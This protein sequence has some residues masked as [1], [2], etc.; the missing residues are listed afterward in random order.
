MI[1]GVHSSKF[2]N[3]K[4]KSN[5]YDAIKRHCIKHP[6]ACDADLTI[7]N[8]LEVICWPT[9][10]VLNPNGLI[11]AE[12]QGEDQ[13]NLV[14]KFVKCCF[15]YYHSS[16]IDSDLHFNSL[17]IVDNFDKLDD[18]YNMKYPTKMCFGDESIL[19]TS[20]TG[21]NRVLAI[22]MVTKK[23]SFIIGGGDCGF[24]DS[25]FKTSK[26]DSPQ[27]LSYDSKAKILYIADTFNDVVRAAHLATQQV[28]TVCGVCNKGLKSIGSYDFIGG[29]EPLA[30]S[31]SSPWD[32]CLIEKDNMNVLII[33]C[34]GTHQIWLYTIGNEENNMLN[35]WKGLK[36]KGQVLIC[37]A[38]NGKERNKNNSYPLQASFAQPSGLSYD[39]IGQ[40]LYL[41]DAESSTIRVISMNDG[42]VKNVVGGDNLQPDNL[43]AYGDCDGKGADAKLQHP[44]DVKFTKIDDKDL[45]IVADTYNGCLKLIDLKTRYCQKILLDAQLNEPNS[46]L[47]DQNKTIWIADTNN[48]VIKTIPNFDLNKFDF[49]VEEF[50]IIFQNNQL[51]MPDLEQMQ[52]DEGIYIALKWDIKYDAPNSWKLK[53]INKQGT[54]SNFNGLIQKENQLVKKNITSVKLMQ[55]DFDIET[56]NQLDIELNIVQCIKSACQM[57][58]IKRTFNSKD[59]L[60]CRKNSKSIVLSFD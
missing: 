28:V 43:F 15:K 12:F 1:I 3:E 35:W 34:A 24:L 48:H 6:V 58:K 7:W 17:D 18:K 59:I 49:K 19:F 42:S 27:G 54:I 38:G 51:K 37:I 2:E 33:A 20:D 13:A 32:L 10:L 5:I 14:N 39:M 60:N 45:L 11:I 36:F 16:L 52:I 31:I 41:A 29:K 8:D 22:D 46:I 30:Q 23:V 25:D 9:L 57:V 50:N 53:L 26:F 47:I 4:S 44:L 21:N 56:L 55:F 40:S